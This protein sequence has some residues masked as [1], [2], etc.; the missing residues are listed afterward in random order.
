MSNLCLRDYITY[1]SITAHGGDGEIALCILSAIHVGTLK[2]L[3]ELEELCEV[4]VRALDEIIDYA[5]YPVTAAEI[6]HKSKKKF[7][8][9]LHR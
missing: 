6:C 7:R 4:A 5:N 3:D 1:S 8:N 9:R 2:D